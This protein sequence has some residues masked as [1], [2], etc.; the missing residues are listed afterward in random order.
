[1]LVSH[2]ENIFLIFW[3][4]LKSASIH[5]R[6]GKARGT[7]AAASQSTADPMGRPASTR[8]LVH[9]SGFAAAGR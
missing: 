8:A 7:A 3:L 4:Y 2:I 6:F 1:M 5:P 9:N